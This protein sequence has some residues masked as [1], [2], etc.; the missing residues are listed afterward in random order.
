MRL[1]NELEGIERGVYSGAIGYFSGRDKCDFSVVIRTLIMQGDKFEFQVGCGIVA[2]S[3][4]E[5]ELEESY[6][7]AKPIMELLNKNPII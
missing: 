1:I 5:K 6:V 3:T 7:K 2:D 4:P